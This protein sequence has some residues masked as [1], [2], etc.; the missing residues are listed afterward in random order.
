MIYVKIENGKREGILMNTI[1]NVKSLESLLNGTNI[2]AQL[3][4]PKLVEKA[5]KRNEGVLTDTGAISVK[6]GKY[7]GRSPKDKYIVQEKSVMD[8]IDWGM[9]TN[10][11][12]KKYFPDYI[13][14][15]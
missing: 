13:Q 2:V 4:V 6:T 14:K 3:S 8:K 5:I 10:P 1:Y 7:T 9:S 11:S 15:Y 12:Q